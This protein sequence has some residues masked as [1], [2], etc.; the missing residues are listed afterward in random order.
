M[1]RSPGPGEDRD[2]EPEPPRSGPV[3][4]GPERERP[5]A[6]RGGRGS[7][8]D[9]D[10]NQGARDR[11]DED[12]EFETPGGRDMERGP[13]PEPARERGPPPASEREAPGRER[14]AESG[15]REMPEP[16][17]DYNLDLP[18]PREEGDRLDRIEEQ[19]EMI[20]DL[21]QDIRDGVRGRRR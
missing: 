17:R 19:N 13:G 2:M 16:P 3:E 12:L 10:R 1:E 9:I 11:M 20:I 8:M 15:G 7:T 5:G 4:R 6:G 21:L 18:E 14:R